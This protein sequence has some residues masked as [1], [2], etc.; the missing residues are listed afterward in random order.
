MSKFVK[1]SEREQE[2][3]M[4]A[5]TIGYLE[6]KEEEDKASELEYLL[7]EKFGTEVNTGKQ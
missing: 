1:F 6:G 2:I 5:K 3:I 4:I 7:N